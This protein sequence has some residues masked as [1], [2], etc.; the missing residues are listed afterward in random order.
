MVT[1]GVC[2]LLLTFR[3]GSELTPQRQLKEDAETVMQQL[4]ALVQYTAVS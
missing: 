4:M 3:L 1:C 2:Y